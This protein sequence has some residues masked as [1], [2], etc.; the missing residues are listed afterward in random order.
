MSRHPRTSCEIEN[1]RHIAMALD[2]RGGV[3]EVRRA[4]QCDEL[5]YLPRMT[6]EELREQRELDALFREVWE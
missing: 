2:K 5:P 6:I 1:D 4:N 3:L